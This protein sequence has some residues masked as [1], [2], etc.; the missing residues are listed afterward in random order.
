[1]KHHET[2]VIQCDDIGAQCGDVCVWGSDISDRVEVI[3]C[4]DISARCGDVGDR[5]ELPAISA[6][7]FGNI[8]FCGV[9]ITPQMC[10]RV[11]NHGDR[12]T[13]SKPESKQVLTQIIISWELRSYENPQITPISSK[14]IPPSMTAE[15]Q[16]G[17][18]ANDPLSGRD[19]TTKRIKRL[20]TCKLFYSFCDGYVRARTHDRKTASQT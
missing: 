12:S 8:G 19:W 7:S 5:A 17:V 13:F 6:R 10:N 9:G 15:F 1:M 11:T 18:G 16:Y 14:I 2:L 3:W 20:A 4:D